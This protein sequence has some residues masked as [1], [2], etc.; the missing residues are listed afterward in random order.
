[1]KREDREIPDN[2]ILAYALKNAV[3][4]SGKCV[5]GS[6]LSP[7]FV[8]GLKK[9]NIKDIMPR[10]NDVVKKVNALSLEE[11]QK[12]LEKLDK[13]L[14]ER[15][16][17]AEGELPE[18]PNPANGKMVMRV[19]PFPSG[20][21]H[22]GNT[23]PL[24]LNDEYIKK[25]GGKL[26]L[27][28]DDTIGSE[29]KQ[30][31]PEAY[32]LLEDGAK[33]LGVNYSKPVIYKSDRLEKYYQFG[34]EIL[35]K[36]KAYVCSCSQEVLRKNREDGKECEHRSQSMEE[37]IKLWK[38]MFDKK[39][40]DGD[41]V[42][43]IKTSMQHPNPAFRERVLFRI[44]SREHPRVGKKYKVWPT[45]EVTWGLDDHDFGMTHIIRGKELMIETDMQKY[46]F[47]IFGWKHP[48]FIHSGLLTI[49]GVKLSK[50]KGQK[51]VREG[52]YI[53]WHDPR[54]WSLQSL[55]RRGIIPVAIRK[56]II[57]M[58]LNQKETTVPV[59]L[60]YQ[61]NRELIK[62][63]STPASFEE[64][65]G[66]AKFNIEILM[67]D[68]SIV[69]GNSDLD[70]KKLKDADIVYFKGLGYTRFNKEEKVKFWFAHK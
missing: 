1:M 46:I 43:R 41:Y 36:D 20:P 10:I 8:E 61:H 64:V 13:L 28:I 50:S 17:R 25:Y 24:I 69:K 16:V 57:A 40:K 58:S 4:H 12:E 60:L 7:L 67:P 2:K 62:D 51:E 23:R 35:N 54:L 14:S 44:C 49:E 3:E 27:F 42:V 6:V 33:W 53:G 19:A 5:A 68:A 29:E 34:E 66:K 18:L 55:E 59:D 65:K 15:D 70:L 48:E 30:I 38:K 32:K 56:F 37:N 47:D 52:R 22:I 31:A 21:A 26:L 45:L 9:E 39:T 63:K 11:Q